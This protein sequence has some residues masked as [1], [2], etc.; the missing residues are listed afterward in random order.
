[1]P[2]RAPLRFVVLVGGLAMAL[3]AC[4]G[5]APPATATS[6]ATDPPPA[7]TAPVGTPAIPAGPPEIALRVDGGDPVAGQLGT[8]LW[9]DG[10]SDA[11]WLAGTPMSIG[12]GEGLEAIVEPAVGIAAWHARYVPW[13]AGG[14]ANAIT[15]AEGSRDPV[16]P[17]PP[18]GTW[19][20]ALEVTFATGLGTA[21]YA[22]QV[23]V[24]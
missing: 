8:Y 2:A 1:M 17:G 4:S 16:F 9:A 19:T 6:G 20:I 3:G 18:A 24:E 15:L 5:S 23:T 12:I 10:G 13:D 14:P 11:P 21:N 7:S 22:W